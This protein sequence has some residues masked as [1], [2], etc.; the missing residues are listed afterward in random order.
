MALLGSIRERVPDVFEDKSGSAGEDLLAEERERRQR[1]GWR[2]WDVLWG[3][4]VAVVIVASALVALAMSLLLGD[5]ILGQGPGP[6]VAARPEPAALH[7]EAGRPLRALEEVQASFVGRP[8]ALGPG[9]FALVEH[10]VTGEVREITPVE[11]EYWEESGGAGAE[12][13]ETGVGRVVWNPGPDGWGMWWQDD[14]EARELQPDVYFARAEWHAKQRDELEHAVRVVSLGLRE[15]SAI[16]FDYWR[17]GPSEELLA[18]A[19]ALGEIHPVVS[20]YGRWEAVP[21]Q[22]HCSEDLEQR[23]RMYVSPG[24]PPENYMIALSGAWVSLGVVAEYLEA[25]GSVGTTIDSMGMRD[26]QESNLR[27]EVAYLVSDLLDAVG[28][29]QVSLER[30]RQE[31]IGQEL[32]IELYLFRGV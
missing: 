28:I 23:Y 17:A 19:S 9:G 5:V 25:I 24:C 13:L 31:S 12:F 14:S 11:I 2:V 1:R 8:M 3:K 10:A 7:P 16:N 32:P 22:W 21:L 20:E 6:F 29:L 26:L 4:K 30:L 27:L 18:I 15:V